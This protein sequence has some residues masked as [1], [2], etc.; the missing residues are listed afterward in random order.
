MP[1]RSPDMQAETPVP[2]LTR[3]IN[4]RVGEVP[5][6]VT[7][8]REEE[9]AEAAL[10]AAAKELNHLLDEYRSQYDLTTVEALTYAAIHLGRDK[11]R[12]LQQQEHSDY[13]GRLAKLSRDLDQALDGLSTQTSH[14][15]NT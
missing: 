1:D 5:M 11:Y 14:R 12:L 3:V 9:E 2:T 15:D 4:L 6:A 7:I 10:R 13:E 8:P